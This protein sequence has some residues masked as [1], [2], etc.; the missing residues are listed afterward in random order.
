[1]KTYRPNWKQFLV[2]AGFIILFFLL[3]DMTNR[4]NDLNRLNSQLFKIETEVGN[5]KATEMALS[6]Q[7][8]YST[9][10]AAVNEY[11][12]NHGLVQEGEKLIV[13]LSE[14]TP[15]PESVVEETQTA[16]AFE[17]QNV[18]WA[19]FFGK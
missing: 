6:T 14:G 19:L 8:V 12:R 17:N 11:A 16:P 10:E 2:L 9:S 4:L 15:Q 18:W 3:M 5:L 1:M 13:P 7:M